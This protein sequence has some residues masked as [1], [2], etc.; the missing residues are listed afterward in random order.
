MSRDSGKD[1]QRLYQVKRTDTLKS[2]AEKFYSDPREW[3][4]LAR[5]N[6]IERPRLLRAGDVIIIPPLR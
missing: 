4:V 3:R 2:I 5:A 1:K 6:N